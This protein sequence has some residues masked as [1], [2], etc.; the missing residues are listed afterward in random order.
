M[1]NPE[2]CSRSPSWTGFLKFSAARRRRLRVS[3]TDR[4]VQVILGMQWGDEGKGKIVDLLG[5][6]SDVVA[7]FQ[8]GANAGHTVR[9]EGRKYILHLLPTG[10]LRPNIQC[11]I[12]NG[13]VIDPDS[14]MEEIR[15][16]GDSG[17]ETAGRLW[18]SHRAHI[19]LPQHKIL[20]QISEDIR[21][22][23]KIG[24][25]GR[26]IGPAYAD[27]AGRLGIRMGD[28]LAP[29]GILAERVSQQVENRNNQM[30]S[31]YG[32]SGPGSREVLLLL[33]RLR[34]KVRDCITDTRIFLNR[35]IGDQK[36]ILLEGAQ[37]AMLDI[38]F[39][40]YPFVTSSNTTV[41]GV[42]TGLG[43]APRE[44]GHVLGVLKAYTTRVGNGPFPTE[45]TGGLG[46]SLRTK[47]AE[48]GSTTGRP[49]RCGWFDS[50]VARYAREI[51]GVDSV[52]LTKLD[53]LD[54]MK[55]LRICTAYKCREEVLE[56][57]PGN[58][59]LLDAAL[60]VYETLPGWQK[61]TGDIREFGKLPAEARKYIE[62]IERLV[63]AP[64]EI[65]S[66]GS[67]REQN[68]FR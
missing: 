33:E 59:D 58:C 37:G 63:G 54:E 2:R 50:V 32:R 20:D 26:G 29:E 10:I 3:K 1:K 35:A 48:F 38:D 7:R 16:L 47:G 5:E 4:R 42:F 23:Q 61:P 11:V 68:I 6:S 46:D 22:G 55:E 27:K 13:V 43:I 31:L 40:T 36:R 44:I 57:F 60:P 19:I 14:L 24:T 15:T 62:R 39:G 21:T 56:D 28:L 17:I 66:V 30:S 53:V 51:N 8:G 34:E 9:F 67:S 52:A 25:T 64:V 45:L 12:G 41:G 18:I 49:R 65:V